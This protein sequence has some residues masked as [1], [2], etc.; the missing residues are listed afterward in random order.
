MKK[1]FFLALMAFLWLPTTTWA[2]AGDHT[3]NENDSGNVD[4]GGSGD[5]WDD[6]QEGTGENLGSI[7]P[8]E[9]QLAYAVLSNPIGTYGE[10]GYTP[11]TVELERLYSAPSGS[12]GALSIPHEIQVVNV[13]VSSMHIDVA[14]YTVVGIGA[15][16]FTNNTTINALTIPYTVRYIGNNAFEDCTN[17][18]SLS[19]TDTT[20]NP[21]QLT[22]IGN[23]AFNHLF[24]M[25]GGEIGLT[26]LDL[27]SSVTTIGDYAFRMN[28][29]ASLTLSEGLTTI[30]SYAFSECN[31][32]ASLEIP[33]TVTTISDHG[34]YSCGAL[35]TVTMSGATTL[36]ASA[37]G[38]CSSLTS[39]VLDNNASGGAAT[40]VDPFNGDERDNITVYVPKG[41]AATY[42]SSS[43]NTL[44]EGDDELHWNFLDYAISSNAGDEDGTYY[45]TYYTDAVGEFGSDVTPYIVTEAHESGTITTQALNGYIPAGTGLLLTASSYEALNNGNTYYYH[46]YETTIG[47]V[48]TADVSGNMLY[49]SIEGGTT[50]EPATSGYY[51]YKLSRNADGDAYSVGFYWGASE[52]GAFTSGAYKAYLSVPIDGTNPTSYSFKKDEGD[53]TGIS[54]IETASEKVVKG[55]YT[56]QGVRVSNMNQPGLYIVDGKKVLVK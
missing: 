11:G 47:V 9:V 54:S 39:L 16:A 52:G 19:I 1:F 21:S 7:V 5:F 28:S 20:G 40:S 41:S 43:W 31:E 53:T 35:T 29:L 33:S 49:G 27:P 13:D 46:P 23:Y 44:V 22:T 8:S 34:F 12:I 55:I 45:A 42:L 14:L 30:G 50:T 18:T 10:G 37:L 3:G 48:T 38:S 36:G 51:Y 25:L 6:E 26:S 32:L 24:A 56:L 15:S 17:L 2:D 4:D